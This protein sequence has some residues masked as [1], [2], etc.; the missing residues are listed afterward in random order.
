MCKIN[1]KL[2]KCFLAHNVMDALGL[3]YPQYCLKPSFEQTFFLQRFLQLA[4]EAWIIP[5]LDPSY[6]LYV[7]IWDLQSYFFK[8]TM[9]SNVQRAMDQPMD[10]NL[11]SRL[12]KKHFP[13]ALLCAQLSKFMKVAKLV[14]V[15]V[16]GSVEDE[17]T[18]STLTFMKTRL[19]NRLC[20]HLDLVVCMF[21]QPF[22]T[23]DTFPYDDVILAQ[24]DEKKK[25]FL[26]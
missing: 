20:E 11:V 12:W 13:N 1:D 19:R 14:V 8:I 21:V 24:I 16:M 10:V 2:E 7:N 17:R 22:Y 26:A 6:Q 23:I 3:V 15:Q 5:N 4:Q 18:F 25:G 9:M